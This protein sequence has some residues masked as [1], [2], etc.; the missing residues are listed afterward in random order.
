VSSQVSPDG[1]YY[2]SGTEWLSTLSPDGRHRWNGKTWVPVSSQVLMPVYPTAAARPRV[3]TSWTRPLQYGVAAFY[4]VSALFSL[5]LPFWMGGIMSQA[6][7]QSIQN[8]QR[9]YPDASPMPAD[10]VNTM[11][12]I[13]TGVAWFAALFSIA[14]C[15]IVIVGA[16]KRWTWIFYVVLVF[17]GLGVISV[18][19]DLIDA[20]AGSSFSGVSGFSMP[21][22]IYWIGVAESI[23]TTALFVWMLVAV[24]KRGPWAMARPAVS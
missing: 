20:L 19:L 22:W 11:T 9:L 12:S 2:W 23:P 8:Q 4:T 13:G 17:L 14:I 3:P 1:M 7:N 6:V 24:I 16:L 10:L 18:P 5:T 21:S 15:V